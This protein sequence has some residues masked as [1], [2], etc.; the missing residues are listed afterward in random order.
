M[1]T[2]KII[3]SNLLGYDSFILI[4][5]IANTFLFLKLNRDSKKLH[6]ILNRTLS[7]PIRTIFNYDDVTMPETLDLVKVEKM[8]Q[9]RHQINQ[10]YHIFY[11]IITIFPLAGILGTVLSLLR[12][13]DFSNSSII[14]N[15]STAL[16]STFWGLVFAIVFRFLD[17]KI[18]SVIQSN[19]EGLNLLLNRIDTYHNKV[20]DK[21]KIVL[22]DRHD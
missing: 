17:G 4:L 15:F 11:A 18:S 12:L 9:T 13:V 10:L 8:E 20:D 1:S 7:L 5:A 19:Q 21:Q 2:I 14:A 16:T 3:L 6:G 22:G